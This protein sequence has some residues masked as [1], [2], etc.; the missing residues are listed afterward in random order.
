MDKKT[1]VVLSFL[2]AAIEMTLFFWILTFGEGPGITWKELFKE[3]AALLCYAIP[4]LL[5]ARRESGIG[6]HAVVLSLFIGSCIYYLAFD[7]AYGVYSDWWYI[8][9]HQDD[10]WRRHVEIM[11]ADQVFLRLQFVAFFLLTYVVLRFIFVR[12]VKM[13]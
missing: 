4:Y 9:A 5:L 8:S 2:L 13:T 12:N 11:I 7:L 3:A 1:A 6:R 10:F